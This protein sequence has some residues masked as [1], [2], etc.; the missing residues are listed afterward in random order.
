MEEHQLPVHEEL[1]IVAS[2][3]KHSWS[4][5]E[6]L[7]LYV[8]GVFALVGIGFGGFTFYNQVILNAAGEDSLGANVSTDLP[9]VNE[10]AYFTITNI[11]KQDIHLTVKGDAS[12]QNPDGTYVPYLLA[13]G[14]RL[15]QSSNPSDD[16]SW[17]TV[18]DRSTG[19]SHGHL[20]LLTNRE[21]Y[22]A[23]T[24]LYPNYSL[25]EDKILQP[26]HTYYL[27]ATQEVTTQ[28][29]NGDAVTT[30]MPQGN[31][32]SF[33]TK[34]DPSLLVTNKDS[35]V[36]LAWTATDA[37][38]EDI[39]YNYDYLLVRAKDSASLTNLAGIASSKLA[40]SYNVTQNT[41]Y[42]SLTS[43]GSA[44]SSAL[45]A[46][47]FTLTQP[48]GTTYYY[49]IVQKGSARYGSNSSFTKII[50]SS[51]PVSVG[52]NTSILGGA[53]NLSSSTA[54][55]TKLNNIRATVTVNNPGK[56]VWIPHGSVTVRTWS[57]KSPTGYGNDSII[58]DTT[59]QFWDTN[60]PKQY[61]IYSYGVSNIVPGTYSLTTTLTGTDS[62]GSA[63]G[64]ALETL[65]N[66]IT[67]TKVTPG[68]TASFKSSSVKYKSDVVINV[69][70]AAVSGYSYLPEGRI[71]IKNLNTGKTLKTISLGTNTPTVKIT[72]KGVKKGKYK[73]AVVY[74]ASTKPEIFENKTINLPLLTVK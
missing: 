69:K 43:S 13:R 62:P 73:L 40:N 10:S 56:L 64:K 47:S 19:S 51:Q 24:I 48:N 52:T 30:W 21:T 36:T 44:A 20:A 3:K 61:E 16:D 32:V 60:S 63:T 67:L 31:I 38:S 50:G 57:P 58:T 70:N 35:L 39:G 12:Y 34:D 25:T 26:S 28:D 9:P 8:A 53:V 42:Q 65:T 33:T 5:K 29:A 17:T 14:W 49:A 37:E 54:L 45:G 71:I 46:G 74:T 15:E 7:A 27:R 11:G 6:K 72:L 66:P 18:A 59:Q 55:T 41:I 2:N 1:A 4:K 68:I 22:Y 23:K